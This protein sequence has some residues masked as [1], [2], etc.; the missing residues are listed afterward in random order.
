MPNHPYREDLADFLRP[1]V[2]SHTADL[3]SV[4]ILLAILCAL[5]LTAAACSLFSLVYAKALV[6]RATQQARDRQTELQSALETAQSSVAEL[7]ATVREMGQQP[8]VVAAAP[9]LIRPGLN[10]TVRSQVLRMHR[11]GE[12]SEKIAK[13]LSVPRQEVELLLKVHRIVLKS[14]ELSEAGSRR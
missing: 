5:A 13:C 8:A 1:K 11:H 6:R 3:S 12:N 7:S 10:L 14:M 4:T 2:T 9:G